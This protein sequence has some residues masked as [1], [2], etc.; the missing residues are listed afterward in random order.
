MDLADPH[1]THLDHTKESPPRPPSFGC[2]LAPELL[3]L[4]SAL[5]RRRRAAAATR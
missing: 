2:G 5:A 4:V 1:C 3:W